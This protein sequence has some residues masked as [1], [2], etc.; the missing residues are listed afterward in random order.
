[1]KR[2]YSKPSLIWI[3]CGERSSGLA[4][5]EVALKDPKK[6]KKKT[7][8]LRTQINGKFNYIMTKTN[9]KISLW[10]LY[11][12]TIKRQYIYSLTEDSE[13]VFVFEHNNAGL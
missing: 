4:K 2:N 5:Q 1:M 7:P 13:V 3:N 11:L 10:S 6:E 12:K 9:N 8:P